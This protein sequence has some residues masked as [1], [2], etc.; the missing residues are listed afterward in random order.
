MSKVPA[1]SSGKAS[2]PAPVAKSNVPAFMQE[3]ASA[4]VGKGT[5]QNQEDNLVPLIYILQAQSPQ[6]VARNPEYIEG[7]VAGDIW[8]RNAPN[9]IVKGDNGILFQPCYFTKDW[10]E[11]KPNR[12]GYAG[13]HDTRPDDAVEQPDPQ[14]KERKLWVRKNGN[15]VVETRYHIGYVIDEATGG[16]MPF[17]IPMSG[18][19]HT[20]SRQWMFSMNSKSIPGVEGSAPSW[21]CLY[22]LRT[23]FV[24]NAKGDW[25]KFDPEDAG[26]VE[27]EAE[28]ERGKKLNE[29]FAAGAHKIEAPEAEGAG[30]QSGG[31][32]NEKM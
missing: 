10:V 22:R 29:A 13:R 30:Q 12:G 32:D 23:K 5:S 4:D 26:W 24:S 31:G 28:Y 9:P 2:V 19:G 8:L 11:W 27:T 3:K 16:V 1:K 7:A 6:V 18:S 17:V 21:A 15:I 14:D 20:V 25:F